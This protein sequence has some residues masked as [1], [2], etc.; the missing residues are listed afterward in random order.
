MVWRVGWIDKLDTSFVVAVKA[1]CGSYLAQGQHVKSSGEALFPC[2]HLSQMFAL[3]LL[4]F[5]EVGFECSPHVVGYV[6][7]WPCIHRR[8]VRMHFQTK[9][10]EILE[11]ISLVAGH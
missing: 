9:T 11:L 4:G 6:G 7:P 8:T 5:E 3:V 1:P 2:L 10:R